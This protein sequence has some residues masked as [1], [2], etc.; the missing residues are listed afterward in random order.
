MRSYLCFGLQVIPFLTVA[1]HGFAPLSTPTKPR[2]PWCL[3][4][5]R[6]AVVG[7]AEDE[8]G[9]RELVQS[10]AR[11]CDCPSEAYSLA[12]LLKGRRG[13]RTDKVIASVVKNAVPEEGSWVLSGCPTTAGMAQALQAAGLD[14]DKVVVVEGGMSTDDVA[15]IAEAFSGKVVEVPA[16]QWNSEEV[17]KMVTSGADVPSPT[18]TASDSSEESVKS[19][20]LKRDHPAPRGRGTLKAGE[21]EDKEESLSKAGALQKK[22][23]RLVRKEKQLEREK[24]MPKA[25]EPWYAAVARPSPKVKTVWSADPLEVR[26][27]IVTQLSSVKVK[28]DQQLQFGALTLRSPIADCLMAADITKPTGIQEA[29]MGRI[30]LGE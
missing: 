13:R 25:E 2:S 14:L 1:V 19:P 4:A 23:Q 21:A 26:S 28:G 12:D 8:G 7:G 22:Q 30:A 17:M 18:A 3:N 29:A 6:I 9:E 10:L 11:L 27:K 5:V 15:G 20:K 16:G 24:E